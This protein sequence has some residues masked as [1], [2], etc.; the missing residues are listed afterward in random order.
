MVEGKEGLAGRGRKGK[1]GKAEA[2]YDN[3]F[4]GLMTCV[5]ISFSKT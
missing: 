2:C 5:K 3:S 1:N 4:K